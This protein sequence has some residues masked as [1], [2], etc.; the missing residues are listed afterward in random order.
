ML[1]N[2]LFKLTTL[3]VALTMIMVRK[4]YLWRYRKAE[5]HYKMYE[6]DDWTI[7]WI[8]DTIT[9]LILIYGF[10][11][12]LIMPSQIDEILISYIQELFL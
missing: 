2:I 12:Y 5:A 4:I 11:A 9:L 1:I 10:M 7:Q 8:G 6:D 3:P